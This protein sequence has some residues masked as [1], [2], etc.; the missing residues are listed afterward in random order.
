MHA[1]RRPACSPLSALRELPP[2]AGRQTKGSLA[3]LV[4]SVT[5]EEY[6]SD[7]TIYSFLNPNFCI[8]P[9]N[10]FILVRCIDACMKKAAV[11]E[12]SSS[13]SAEADLAERLLTAEAA[14][15]EALDDR[16]RLVALLTNSNH[17]TSQH[18][19]SQSAS[20]QKQ[21]QQQEGW[22][23]EAGRD[24]HISQ[25]HRQ[26][27]PPAQR[28][29]TPEETDLRGRSLAQQ[30]QQQH[31]AADRTGSNSR[32]ELP[33]EQIKELEPG[34][35]PAIVRLCLFVPAKRYAF[36]AVPASVMYMHMTA[37]AYIV[38]PVD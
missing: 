37:P 12:G 15:E 21:Q 2:A 38:G 13:A 26:P 34:P 31:D 36:R 1:G 4:T 8:V 17:V 32:R 11:P 16:D 19:R 28:D 14:L 6:L 10:H 3:V 25:Q 33:W 9:I 29:L 35:Q 24:E 5:E 22:I 7:S 27:D 20:P 18:H 23:V 30:Q